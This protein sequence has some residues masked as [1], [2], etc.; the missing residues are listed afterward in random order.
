MTAAYQDVLKEIVEKKK[1]AAEVRRRPPK[2][3]AGPVIKAVIAVILPPIVAAV[4]IFNPFAPAPPPPPRIPD[5][6]LSWQAALVDAALTIRD[7]RDSAGVFPID[8][9]AAEIPLRGVTFTVD[10]PEAFMLQTFTT[11]GVVT[12]WMDS[13]TLGTGPRPVVLDPSFLPPSLP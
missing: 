7:W 10:G 2:K 4:W 3:R 5:E 6:M 11:E 12:V 8:L 13:T 1:K 9:E